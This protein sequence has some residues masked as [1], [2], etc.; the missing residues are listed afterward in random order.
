MI[1]FYLTKEIG[2]NKGYDA[3]ILLMLGYIF[4]DN[5]WNFTS[6][7]MY[8][9]YRYWHSR[10]FKSSSNERVVPPPFNMP[11]ARGNNQKRRN[12]IFIGVPRS[13]HGLE[14]VVEALSDLIKSYS[15]LKLEII[16][17]S[18]YL[19]KII[20]YAIRLGVGNNVIFHG[21]IPTYDK[22]INEIMRNGICGL[23]IMMPSYENFSYYTWPSK[24][25]HYLE[26]GLPVITTK[27]C[28]VADV[29]ERFKVGIVVNC[30]CHDIKRAIE[31]LIKDSD[32]FYKI[33]RN[34]IKMATQFANGGHLMKLLKEVS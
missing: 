8:A 6:K 28:G 30:T 26:N 7:I 19:S 16:G 29:I 3:S 4:S 14:I 2:E 33:Q 17:Q 22:R 9:R 34:I 15:D 11:C 27:Y 12:V 32:R 1:Y 10:V 31:L 20:E 5:V 13:F 25:L 24:I 18:E 21:Y 23:A